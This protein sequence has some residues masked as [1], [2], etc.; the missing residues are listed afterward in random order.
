MRLIPLQATLAIGVV[1][2]AV[3]AQ[4]RVLVVDAAGGPGAQYTSLQTAV[5]AAAPGDTLL[6]RNGS[7]GGFTIG[8][9]LTLIADTDADV[10]ITGTALVQN[11]RAGETV[12]VRGLDLAPGS[13]GLTIDGC[14][15]P[16]WVED[17]RSA[18]FGAGFDG[19]S[20]T[21]CASVTIVGSTFESAGSGGSGALV[22]RSRAFFSDSTLIGGSA[23]FEI[24]AGPGL[25]VVGT[26]R[27]TAAAFV[28]DSIAVGGPELYGGRTFAVGGDGYH[29]IRLLDTAL[30]GY[31]F[32]SSST[33]EVRVLPGAG[34]TVT[35][36]SPVREGDLVT[37]AVLAQ[38]GDV[39]TVLLAAEPLA[40]Q[41]PFEA[42]R[43]VLLVGPPW[44]ATPAVTVPASG[45]LGV[46]LPVPP[47]PSG[48]DAL[49]LHGQ[50]VGASGAG[51]WL[52]AATSVVALDARF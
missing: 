17:C 20:V 13:G 51:L 23:A 14:A 33:G 15:G 35:A 38:P 21:D 6:V 46:P 16:V 5:R 30:V 1:T 48:V 28:T 50:V 29:D 40:Q 52:G 24:L 27:T 41:L 34:R 44:I 19:L 11:T 36:P 8:K 31:P 49:R 26:R 3:P 42:W 45:R 10:T 22:T 9:A 7:Y 18:R 39:A 4:G 47:L 12:L 43:G 37:L 25:R 32:Y 2:M